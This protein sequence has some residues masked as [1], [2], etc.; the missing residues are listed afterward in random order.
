VVVGVVSKRNSS[1]IDNCIHWTFTYLY[2]HSNKY[3]Y[4][5]NEMYK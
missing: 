1:K 5:S 3:I 4:V 2:K